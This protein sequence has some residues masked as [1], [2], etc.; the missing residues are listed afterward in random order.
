[1]GSE[2]MTDYAIW[3]SAMV[4]AGLLGGFV[5]GLLGVGGGI[6]IVPVLYFVLGGMGVDD[7]IRMKLAV[8]TSLA[9]IL[10]TSLSSARSHYRKDAVD[11]SLLKTWGIPIFIGVVAGTA[12]GGYVSGMVL[13][14]VFAVVALLVAINM[15][16]RANASA[17]RDGFPNG[18]VKAFCG[19][20]VGSISAMMGIG[21]GT[22]SVPILTAFGF[23]IR[24]AVGT[25]SAI[26]F[27]IAIPGTIGYMLAG[28]G[29]A[30][31]PAGS[32][33]YVNF[34]ALAALAPLTMLVA[35]FGAKVAHMIP[36]NI[37]SYAFSAFLLVTSIR[38]FVDVWQHL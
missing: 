23:D 27:I 18:P 32:V 7:D 1:M 12:T 21:G 11:F 6:V 19:F 20:V 29:E 24:R 15:T 16:L 3:I 13:T 22:L 30:N 28:L 35:P 10:F 5:A 37:L 9:T 2:L 36:R 33:G 8:A 25:A 26:G 34:I 38:M 14:L 31:L 4:F 17:L